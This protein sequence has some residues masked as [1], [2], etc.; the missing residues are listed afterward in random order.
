MSICEEAKCR[1]AQGTS[2]AQPQVLCTLRLSMGRYFA[3]TNIYD[4]TE[5]D[6]IVV[7]LDSVMKSK[8]GQL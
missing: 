1:H 3:R 5:S 2:E 7:Y 8:A 4:C 6:K